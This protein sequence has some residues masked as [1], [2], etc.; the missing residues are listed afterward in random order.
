MSF[1]QYFHSSIKTASGLTNMLMTGDE[2]QSTRSG[3]EINL[4]VLDG[5][6]FFKE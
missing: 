5:E 6:L 4:I 1:C 2:M 3:D